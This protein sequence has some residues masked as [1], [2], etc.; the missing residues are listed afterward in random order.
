MSKKR[1]PVRSSYSQEA[2]T[3]LHFTVYNWVED[4]ANFLK[5]HDPNHL[6]TI[7]TFA[8]EI[9]PT[10]NINIFEIDELDYI[11]FDDYGSSRNH[12]LS[13]RAPRTDK[14][15]N[16][17]PIPGNSVN[18]NPGNKPVEILEMGHF[19]D[20]AHEMYGPSAVHNAF[21]SSAFMGSIGSGS[22]FYKGYISDIGLRKATD[23]DNSTMYK[24][25]KYGYKGR[26]FEE[27]PVVA[28]DRFWPWWYL[29][30]EGNCEIRKDVST[31]P[32][33]DMY[34]YNDPI[35]PDFMHHL[36]TLKEFMNVV[37]NDN[38]FY[39]QNGVRAQSY[40]PAAQVE[41][42]NCDAAN[43]AP[44]SNYDALE[45]FSLVTDDQLKATGWVHN[46]SSYWGNHDYRHAW[47]DGYQSLNGYT[48]DPLPLPPFTSPNSYNYNGLDYVG[49]SGG[50][51]YQDDVTQDVQ[52]YEE[53]V[54][55][56]NMPFFYHQK[57][58]T[59]Q[60]IYHSVVYYSWREYNHWINFSS[61]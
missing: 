6:R 49:F 37:L 17:L 61:R 25:N 15:V 30:S 55:G 46:R 50:A 45:A 26:M 2:E 51:D 42:T 38:G 20:H 13:L 43:S 57:P 22:Y 33:T 10:P 52:Q 39:L 34:N 12:N 36:K 4:M 7:C 9:Y 19:G 18:P 56:A 58:K 32:W 16:N 1:R 8:S 31:Y 23:N 54:M 27:S 24:S 29:I 11:S 47:I 14:L 5:D 35:T 41:Y 48:T 21:W 28:K 59:S 60:F 40:P 3:G 53:S 44:Y